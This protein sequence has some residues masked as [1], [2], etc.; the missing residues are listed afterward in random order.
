MR[1]GYI[2]ASDCMQE[3]RPIQSYKPNVSSTTSVSSFVSSSKVSNT[4]SKCKQTVHTQAT[5]Q[6]FCNVKRFLAYPGARLDEDQL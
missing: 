3:T 6:L 5:A 4:C 1:H 2:C